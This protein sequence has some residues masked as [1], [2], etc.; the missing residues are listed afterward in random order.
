MRKYEVKAMA[1]EVADV[2][3]T[4]RKVKA[5]WARTGNVDRDSDIIVQGAFTKTIMECGPSGSNEI[6]ALANHFAEFKAALGKPSEIYEEGDA[7]I[8]IT[9]IVDT[10]VGEDILKLYSAGCIN[11]HS[12]G[13]ATIKSDFQ[14]SD[15]TVRLIKEVKLYEGGPV[16]WGANPQ[17]PTLAITKS[18][19]NIEQTKKDLNS[20]LECLLKAF[21]HG[22]FNDTTFSLLE[23][24]IKQIQSKILE[25]STPPAVKAVEPQSENE[26]LKALKETNS[27]LLKLV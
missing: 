24:Q 22:T 9:N 19:E 18:I 11:Q 3:T 10:E 8:S 12:I 15:Q 16:L 14:N 5:V 13:F 2:D 20:E 26:L 7:L 23:I 6:W 27:K 17:T 21:K 1:G 4:G 25:L